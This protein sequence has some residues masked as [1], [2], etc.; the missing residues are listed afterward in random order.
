ML[1]EE[2]WEGRW[3]SPYSYYPLT[4]CLLASHRDYFSALS[5]WGNLNRSERLGYFSPFSFLW[6]G[7][8][9]SLYLNEIFNKIFVR[10]SVGLPITFSLKRTAVKWNVF[11]ML[12]LSMITKAT[13]PRSSD[14]IGSLAL[15]TYWHPLTCQIFPFASHSKCRASA[16]VLSPSI[17]A[18]GQ[19]C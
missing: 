11:C 15:S 9:R 13:Q 6:R 16:L 8:G 7:G 14:S 4:K 2:C 3:C 12:C 19:C 10:L 17:I 18:N 5:L 1:D